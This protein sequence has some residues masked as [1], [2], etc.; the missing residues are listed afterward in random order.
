MVADS[1]AGITEISA[2]FTGGEACALFFHLKTILY[3]PLDK[4]ISVYLVFQEEQFEIADL[5]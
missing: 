3:I 4:D 1:C 2:E 5:S